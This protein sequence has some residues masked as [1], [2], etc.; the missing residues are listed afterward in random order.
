[1]TKWLRR[2]S[3]LDTYSDLCMSSVMDFFKLTHC[4]HMYRLVGCMYLFTFDLAKRI[5][6]KTS[7]RGMQD[8][9][10]YL[11]GSAAISLHLSTR[12]DT[13]RDPDISMQAGLLSPSS[14]RSDFTPP[15]RAHF[16]QFTYMT[17]EG[18]GWKEDSAV[19]AYA[20]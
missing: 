13:T 5:P 17:T 6:H 19:A 16:G 2:H 11:D 8:L 1:M 12:H 4:M 3:I 10:T 18:Q 7:T 9:S 14:L 20:S 15:G